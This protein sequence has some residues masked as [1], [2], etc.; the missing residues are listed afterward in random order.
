MGTNNSLVKE[1]FT[2]PI[3][4]LL[5]WK[6]LPPFQAFVVS[7][8]EIAV[9]FV[10]CLF[11]KNS[12]SIKS[13][14]SFVVSLVAITPLILIIISRIMA[15]GDNIPADIWQAIIDYF[16]IFSSISSIGDFTDAVSGLL[17]Y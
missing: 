2:L 7:L 10:E 16:S 13:T 14:I 8:L 12:T 15:G 6:L 17:A 1:V 4:I 3:L 11:K 5:T 9:V